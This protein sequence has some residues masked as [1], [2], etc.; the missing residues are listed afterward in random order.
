[1]ASLV[2]NAL[3]VYRVKGAGRAEPDPANY[4]GRAW[5][6][7]AWV[8]HWLPA[9]APGARHNGYLG[10]ANEVFRVE[11]LHWYMNFY[12]E[13]MDACTKKGVR[14]TYGDF[15][16]GSFGAL[17]AIVLRELA[18]YGMRAGHLLAFNAYWDDA[19]PALFWYF[20]ALTDRVPGVPFIL[21][22]IGWLANDARYPGRVALEQ[23]L[24]VHAQIDA[25]G[26]QGGA[27]WCQNGAGGGWPHS[28]IGADW[29]WI[30]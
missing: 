16:V 3:T 4:Q 14:C 10:F 15:S 27:L 2:P 17:D 18:E 21:K 8:D 30:P 29:Q 26:Y 24:V 9:L 5:T 23:L 12:I 13:L 28:N 20:K 19:N 25:P 11:S 22:E 1:M 7:A 6:G